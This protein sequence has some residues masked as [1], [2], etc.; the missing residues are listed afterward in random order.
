MKSPGKTIHWQ[1]PHYLY[2]KKT[3][4]WYTHVSVF[5]FIVMVVFFLLKQWAGAAITTL[6]FWVFIAK[7]DDR[8]KTVNYTIS[9]AGI[10]IDDRLLSF[11]EMHSFT[12]DTSHATPV[13]MLDL[14]YHFA[15]PQTVLVKKDNLDAVLE[16][17]IQH[18]PIRQDF[19]VIR[20]LTHW[21]HY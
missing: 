2:K 3:L 12:V 16:I 14:N 18:V 10:K 15:F 4:L 19:S 5:F 21:L 6:L 20:W 7:S 1:A 17:L 9:N 13:I 8:P 11:S